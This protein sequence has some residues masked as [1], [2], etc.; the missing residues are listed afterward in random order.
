MA[1]KLKTNSPDL[2]VAAAAWAFRAA[3]P[4]IAAAE[5]P[6]PPSL[7]HGD[8]WEMRRAR[9]GASAAAI[10]K[11]C[12]DLLCSGGLFPKAPTVEYDSTQYFLPLGISAASRAARQAQG[13]IQIG[14][15]SVQAWPARMV[16]AYHDGY[17]AHAPNVSTPAF[18]R[19]IVL[20]AATFLAGHFAEQMIAKRIAARAV[21][22]WIRES[23]ASP[24]LGDGAGAA[25][26]SA[27]E[28]F[29]L[30]E[31]SEPVAPSRKPRRSL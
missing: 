19:H 18:R 20:R 22:T 8:D 2:A 12:V 7:R 23:C 15:S 30:G 25:I 5:A 16:I 13:A 6:F 14:E 1:K 27:F 11:S 24:M 28:Q 9:V 4:A 21:E 10:A 17:E 3:A 26:R 29:A 31:A